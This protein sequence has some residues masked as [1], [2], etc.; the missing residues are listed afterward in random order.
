MVKDFRARLR[1]HI[2]LTAALVGPV[3]IFLGFLAAGLVWVLI[4]DV[5]WTQ[6]EGGDPIPLIHIAIFTVV[7]IVALY[8]L[9]A[10]VLGKRIRLLVN[11]KQRR[12]APPGSFPRRP[13]GNGYWMVA[14]GS[15][16]AVFF[17]V[18]AAMGWL[19]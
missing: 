13:L 19:T 9:S 6:L 14:V 1:R 18:A 16:I 2:Y 17:I 7:W 3:A 8:R 10:A 4:P 12:Y 5:G 15:G 11:E